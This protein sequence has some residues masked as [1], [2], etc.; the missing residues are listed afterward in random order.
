MRRTASKSSATV[1]WRKRTKSS[2]VAASSLAGGHLALVPRLREEIDRRGRPDIA[3]VLGGVVPAQDHPVLREAGVRAFFGPG[4]VLIEAADAV[5]ELLL[6]D[7]RPD[8]GS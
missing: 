1:S 8:A 2:Q 3:L 4:T 6:A 7:R 5:L